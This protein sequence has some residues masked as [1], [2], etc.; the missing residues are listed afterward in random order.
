MIE[1]VEQ[2]LAFLPEE[3]DVVVS[4]EATV[5]GGLGQPVKFICVGVRLLAFFLGVRRGRVLLVATFTDQELER[6]LQRLVHLINLFVGPRLHLLGCSCASENWRILQQLAALGDELRLV[7]LVPQF[8]ILYCRE[9][10]QK[11]VDGYLP[12]QGQQ[13]LVVEI[14]LG[15][16]A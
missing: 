11:F 4:H 15:R 7:Y 9:P 8:H 10:L 12:R 6:I 2:L 14:P 13:K 16:I 3:L 1:L 5:V